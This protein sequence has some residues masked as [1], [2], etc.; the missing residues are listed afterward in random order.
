MLI[1][2]SIKQETFFY[3]RR[4][5]DAV[6]TIAKLKVDKAL[7]RPQF[8]PD[9]VDLFILRHPEEK[10]FSVLPTYG[11]IMIFVKQ[12]HCL[13][14]YVLRVNRL[15]LSRLHSPQANLSDTQPLQ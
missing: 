1:T 8:E 6:P 2:K 3:P 9:I 4:S 7:L 15:P 13:L 11:F 12:F 14:I 10:P 5:S